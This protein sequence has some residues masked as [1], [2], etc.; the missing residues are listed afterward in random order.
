M[1]KYKYKG[2]V[3]DGTSV[4]MLSYL[5]DGKANANGLVW[6]KHVLSGEEGLVLESQFKKWFERVDYWVE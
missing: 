1:M 3:V 5:S 4:E 2:K 6:I